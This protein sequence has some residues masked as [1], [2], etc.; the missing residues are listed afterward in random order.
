MPFPTGL[1]GRY[2]DQPL[3]VVVYAGVIVGTGVTMA[4]LWSY[5]WR[6]R[7]IDACIECPVY[8]YML[9]QTLP[10]PAVFAVSIPV[11]LSAG[12]TAGELTWLLALPAMIALP[13]HWAARP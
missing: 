13:R 12:A 5:A 3:A 4:S 11:T 9:V 7:L 6:R 8:R 1:L 10:V 2:G